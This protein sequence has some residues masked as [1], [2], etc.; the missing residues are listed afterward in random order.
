MQAQISQRTRA[1][2]ATLKKTCRPTAVSILDVDAGWLALLRLPDVHDLSDAA[3]ALRL[4]ERAGVLV[5][6]GHLYGLAGVHVAVSL[7]T[8]E[9]ILKA[10]LDRLLAE[11]AAVLA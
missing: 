4:V 11:V 1:N 8:P 10:G 7:L 5:Q 3:W 6:P 9:S 2:L